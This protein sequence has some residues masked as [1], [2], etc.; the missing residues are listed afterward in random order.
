VLESEVGVEAVEATRPE[1]LVEADP[2]HRFVERGRGQPAVPGPP[3]LLGHDETRI[4]QHLKVFLHA[5]QAD[6][7]RR[8]EVTDGGRAVAQPHQ[9][10]AADR[11][12]QAGEDAIECL[13]LNHTVHCTTVNRSVQ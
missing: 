2:G 11:V 1:T 6:P 10:T 8:R 4:F 13:L 5:G 7:S 9:D 12:G 3:D